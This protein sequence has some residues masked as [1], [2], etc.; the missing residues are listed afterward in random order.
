MNTAQ[1]H[2][3]KA[4]RNADFLALIPLSDDSYADW[5]IVVLFYRALHLV[6]ALLHVRGA[7]HGAN[8]AQRNAAVQE[9]F[10]RSIGT[11]YLRLYSRSRLVRYEQTAS[12]LADYQRLLHED[13]TPIL[14]EVRKELAEA[15]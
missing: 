12:L 15:V 7:E 9:A 1:D 10:S 2:L 14:A 6:S 4:R 5:A 3:I 8:H 13:F 11:S